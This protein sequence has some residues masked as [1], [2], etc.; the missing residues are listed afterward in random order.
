MVTIRCT[1][2]LLRHLD[3]ATNSARPESTPILGDWYA[4]LLESD[5][6]PFVLFCE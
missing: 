6:D 3:A 2:K 5:L 1:Q 4:N